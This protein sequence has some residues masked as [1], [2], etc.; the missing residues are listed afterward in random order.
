[1]KSVETVTND[2]AKTK[3]PLSKNSALEEVPVEQSTAKKN[4]KKS[5]E[6]TIKENQRAPIS[7][8][9][10]IICSNRQYYLMFNRG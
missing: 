8:D 7:S 5:P 4:H 6:E 10:E 1:M 2:P 3:D 9:E